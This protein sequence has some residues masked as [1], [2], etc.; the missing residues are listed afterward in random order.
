MGT[1]YL[2]SVCL[3]YVLGTSCSGSRER[4]VLGTSCNGY[5]LSWV[6]VVLG[7]MPT[8][9]CITFSV[10]H[11]ETCLLTNENML[12]IKEI[13]T[14]RS[15]IWQAQRQQCCRCARQ[16]SKQYDDLNY[17]SRS[18]E[19][20]RDLTIRRL[21][22]YWN[23]ALLSDAAAFFTRTAPPQ[24]HVTRC[25][26]SAGLCS[27]VPETWWRHHALETFSVLLTL[28]AGNSPVTGEFPSQSSVKRSF[29]VFFD[30]GL[31]KRLSKQSRRQW[32][33]TPS[34]S[35]WRHTNGCLRTLLLTWFYCH[36]DMHKWSLHPLFYGIVITHPCPIFICAST[37]PPLK[38]RPWWEITPHCGCNYLCIAW[39]LCWL[40]W[41]MWVKWSL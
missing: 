24:V 40:S 9:I 11:I 27:K 39:Y 29:D 33:E 26:L 21:I 32:F 30:L 41:S 17:Q 15:D 13:K 22:G 19:T 36:Q 37:K 8:D 38:F 2:G 3:A 12:Q 14:D 6:R 23:S 31:N 34:S 28:C 18:F 25:W 1:T 5:E 10:S 7:A 20:S 16:I 35:L 4:V